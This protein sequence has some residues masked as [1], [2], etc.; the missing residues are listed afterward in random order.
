MIAYDSALNINP[1]NAKTWIG[2]AMVH[3]KLGKYKKKHLS[4][5]TKLSQ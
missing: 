3:L 2:K 5:A 4:P 1:D